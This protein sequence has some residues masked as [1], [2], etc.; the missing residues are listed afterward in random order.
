M[1]RQIPLPAIIKINEKHNHLL[2]SCGSLTFL[3]IDDTSDDMT[4]RHFLQYF[5]D[6]LGIAESIK[7]HE[8]KVLINLLNSLPQTAANTRINPTYN[9]IK[10]LYNNWRKEHYGLATDSIEKIKQKICYYSEQS[11][12]IDIVEGSPWA[13]I[14]VTPI[15][16]RC[17]DLTHSG[18]TIFIDST[19]SVDATQSTLTIMLTASKAGALPIAIFVHEGQTE[20][21]YFQ[22]FT[23]LNKYS[24]SAFGGKKSPMAFM[25][26]N[27]SAEKN[28]LRM[29]WPESR[30]LLCHFHVAQAEWRWLMS[31]KN[32]IPLNERRTYMKH[33]QQMMYSDTEGNFEE[34]V[35]TF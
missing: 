30:Q 6:G 14:I 25:T 13:V 28:A 19:S 7:Q 17:Q 3:R 22:I 20:E 27:S 32:Q 9:M 24:T 31:S 5:E 12:T 10:H 26:D 35:S 23:L 4:K 29:V 8:N 1:K 2:N 11:I 16:K 33:F 18:E 15:M 34:A 21:S